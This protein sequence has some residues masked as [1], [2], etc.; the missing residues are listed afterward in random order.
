MT[1][2]DDELKALAIPARNALLDEWAQDE[3]DAAEARAEYEAELAAERWY[4]NG[5]AHAEII[6][7]ENEQD[8]LMHPFD[9]IYDR[10]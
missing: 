2:T 7:W 6:W 4:E 3:S 1:M 10:G 8:R 9:P 5:G